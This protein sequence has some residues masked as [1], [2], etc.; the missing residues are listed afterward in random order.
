MKPTK[1]TLKW[2]QS[3]NLGTDQ[4]AGLIRRKYS[5]GLRPL[6]VQEWF[7]WISAG[8]EGWYVPLGSADPMIAS[9][10]ARELSQEVASVGWE[11]A[12]VRVSREFAF[13][14]F[15]LESP[16]ACTYA[17]LFT[18]PESPDPAPKDTSAWRV[19]VAV[20]EPDP[21]FRSALCNWL[22][23]IPGCTCDGWESERSWTAQPRRQS[24]VQVLLVNRLSLAYTGTAFKSFKPETGEGPFVF[25]YG[26]YSDG[27]DIFASVSGV[28][29][30]YYLRRR[31]APTLL[32]PLAGAVAS[33]RLVPSEVPRSLRRYFQ[34]LFNP[35]A[36]G[37]GGVT[38]L[39]TPRERQIL[40]C[41]QRGLHDKEIASQLGISPLTVHTHLKHIFEKL[42]AHT[43]TEAVV[44]YLEK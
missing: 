9:R 31:Y 18:L 44:K 7:T 5:A 1:P 11:R 41:L 36:G 27:D 4:P 3:P 37:S 6:G 38:T 21:I 19:R 17:T 34:N 35:N 13:G 23:R 12:G 26:I 16:V 14:I 15:W 25:G 29:A 28:D 30:G 2:G 32:D 24:D 33:N 22:G 8:D 39:L 10:A 42:D 20:I 43:R 40:A